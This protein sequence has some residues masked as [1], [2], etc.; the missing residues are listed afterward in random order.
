LQGFSLAGAVAALLIALGLAWTVHQRVQDIAVQGVHSALAGAA[1]SIN[2]AI[3]PAA[4]LTPVTASER[5]RLDQLTVSTLS[6]AQVSGFSVWDARGGIWYTTVPGAG[7][8]TTPA[9][10]LAALRGVAGER[11][12][13]SSATGAPAQG[14]IVQVFQPLYAGSAV[15]GAYEVDGSLALVDDQA[16]HTEHMVWLAIAAGVSLLYIVFFLLVRG[17]SSSLLQQNRSNADLVL[18]ADARARET[19]RLIAVGQRLNAMNDL[20]G[21]IAEVLRACGE[22]FALPNIAVL[23]Y[24][25]RDGYLHFQA[26][27][28]TLASTT[29]SRIALGQGVVGRA[30][31]ERRM[32]HVPDSA[33]EADAY[34]LAVATRS[35]VAV[36]LMVSHKI[37]GVLNAESPNRAAFTG[38]DIAMLSALADQAARAVQNALL[39]R[40]R[41]EAQLAALT[42]VANSLDA[43]D[44]YTAGHS[45]RVRD[46]S[47]IIAR[48]M[49]SWGEE[50]LELLYRAA[51]LHDIGKIGVPDAVLQKPGR[52]TDEER[53]IME[54]HP[55]IGCEILQT[56]RF[57]QPTL[58]FIRY[59]HERWDGKGYPDGIQGTE[60]P[61]GARVIA[62]ADT[63]DAMTSDRPYRQGMSTMRAY[64]AIKEGRGTQFDP[65]VAEVMLAVLRDGRLVPD[66]RTY[67][68]ADFAAVA[69]A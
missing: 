69:N 28:G 13:V 24:D 66:G 19:R 68:R 38:S 54:L 46:Y 21:V 8:A 7:A 25:E 23:L 4:L 58:P 41:E 49:G 16:L 10:I 17:I 61:L 52:L 55:V 26:G 60:I 62:V 67:E 47:L 12:T 27:S 57:L 2:A 44:R 11:V 20:K 3:P 45:R 40:E 64:D 33:R 18:K 50:D 59:H 43:R 51:H 56:V 35:Q 30:A 32:N 65:A 63:F 1:S 31:Q 36:P 53:V 48:A 29:R 9:G 5:A 39:D 42:A 22:V 34:S 37:L 6:I 15:A 14:R